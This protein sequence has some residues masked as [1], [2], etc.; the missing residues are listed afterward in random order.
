[1]LVWRPGLKTANK[2]NSENFQTSQRLVAIHFERE[3]ILNLM[4]SHYF[5][6]SR[7]WH[8]IYLV[9]WKDIISSIATPLTPRLTKQ[10]GAVQPVLGQCKITCSLLFLSSKRIIYFCFCAIHCCI[11]LKCL[12]MWGLKSSLVEV[13]L[14]REDTDVPL[15]S[16]SR[17]AF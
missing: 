9:H 17:S 6:Y 7:I 5:R 2:I 1:M 4:V 15:Y 13:F 16:L 11:S 12:F 10:E 8:H 3:Y 14:C